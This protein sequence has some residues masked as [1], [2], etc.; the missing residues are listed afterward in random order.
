M[1]KRIIILVGPS[2]SGKTSLGQALSDRGFHKLITTTTRQPRPGEQDG[3]DYYFKRR[4]ELDESDF[5]E[6]TEYNHRIY[7][8][9]KREVHQML[10]SHD[11]VHVSLDRNGM[12]VMKEEFPDET[13]VLYV[14]ISLEEMARRMQQRG[15]SQ[16]KICERLKFCQEMGELI[17]PEE[18]DH[19]IENHHL[20]SATKE[21]L[22]IIEQYTN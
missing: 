3:I 22:T 20:E 12:K 13:I 6:Q 11:V 5:I 2:G 19:V 1:S 21:L 7:G 16:Q 10:E 15:D 9:T 8:L 18:T 14:S 4:D 17:P